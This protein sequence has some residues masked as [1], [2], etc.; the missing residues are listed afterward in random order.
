MQTEQRTYSAGCNQSGPTSYT[1]PTIPWHKEESFD[2]ED[3]EC[4]VD[5]L[6]VVLRKADDSD[7]E[8]CY[9]CCDDSKVP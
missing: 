8:K 3:V 4:G 9:A 7:N 6:V 5:E 1:K 2:A